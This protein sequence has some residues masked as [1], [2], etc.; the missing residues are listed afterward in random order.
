MAGFAVGQLPDDP[1]AASALFHADVLPH[2]LAA[3]DAGDTVLTLLFTPAA[4]PHRDWRAAAVA[5]IARERAP[6]RI[7]AV[8]SDDQGAIAAALAYL[9]KADGVTGQYLPLDSHGA[10][11]VID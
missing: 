11:M 8:A 9:D 7:N 2:I 10:G 3:L 4:H 1:L 6:A 5:T